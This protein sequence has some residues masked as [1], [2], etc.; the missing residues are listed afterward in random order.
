MSVLTLPFLRT[1]AVSMAMKTLPS[2]SKRTSTLSRVV[3]A[4]LADDH[5]LALGQALMNVLLPVLRRPT[6]ASFIA[7]WPAAVSSSP[8]AGQQFADAL[9]QLV[10][11]AVLHGADGR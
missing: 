7:T 4:H 5:A 6:M 3:P 8:A 10:L 11:A 9:E 1:P 2:R